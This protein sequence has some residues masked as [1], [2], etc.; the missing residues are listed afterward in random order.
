MAG[1]RFLFVCSNGAGTHARSVIVP[2][3]L[4]PAQKSEHVAWRLLG[5]N[6]RELGR[7]PIWY[8]DVESCREAVRVLKREIGG[9]TPAI[10]SVP[11][12][13]GA[14]SWRLA[15][16]GTP[17]AVAGRPYHRQR[18]CAYN[19]NH[20]VAAVPDALIADEPCNTGRR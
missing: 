15:V 11:Q 9:V 6:N 4:N 3:T 8:P 7:S 1:P 13:G 19:L 17:V 12:P 5:A 20:F 10:M 14:W 2:N 18:E 16:S